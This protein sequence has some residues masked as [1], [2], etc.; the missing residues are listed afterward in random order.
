MDRDEHDRPGENILA[1]ALID[2]RRGDN[3]EYDQPAEE[4][5][6]GDKSRWI[7]L[8][9]GAL[10]PSPGT[11]G[12]GSGGGPRGRHQRIRLSLDRTPSPAIPR[13]TGGGRRG[14]VRNHVIA[15]RA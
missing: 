9:I 12:E 14:V 2:E 13:S 8:R 15:G 6:V 4:S 3:A 11:P 10:A 7:S 5:Y 1:P